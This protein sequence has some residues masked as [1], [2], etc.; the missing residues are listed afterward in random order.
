MDF[1]R[2]MKNEN[3]P[4]FTF[5]T[6]GLFTR[7]NRTTVDFYTRTSGFHCDWDGVQSNVEFF[8]GDIR[9]ILFPREDF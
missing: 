7:D 1:E 2:K 3:K 8:L 9:I 5:N 4:R 6:I